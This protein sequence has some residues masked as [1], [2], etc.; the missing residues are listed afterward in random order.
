MEANA[1][2][3]AAVAIVVTSEAEGEAV[4]TSGVEARVDFVVDVVAEVKVVRSTSKTKM[5][6]PAWEA[7]SCGLS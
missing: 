3:A 1:G 7:H 2:E 6:S 5:L 4:A